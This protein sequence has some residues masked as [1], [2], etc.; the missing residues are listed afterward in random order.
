MLSL[1]DVILTLSVLNDGLKE[2]F[3]TVEVTVLDC[4]DLTQAPFHLAAEGILS[5]LNISKSV[6]VLQI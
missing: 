4:P 6:A 3:S 1:I 2:N 5:T